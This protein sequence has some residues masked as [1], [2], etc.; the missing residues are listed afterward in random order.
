MPALHATICCCAKM[1]RCPWAFAFK[2]CRS[3]PGHPE[4]RNHSRACASPPISRSVSGRP[5]SRRRPQHDR[6]LEKSTSKREP[7]PFQPSRSGLP[8]LDR[9]PSC[10][11]SS[12]FFFLSFSS[13]L[14]P[15]RSAKRRA[16]GQAAVDQRSYL[17]GFI[18]ILSREP[19]VARP[20]AQSA[21]SNSRERRAES[22]G[23]ERRG[24]RERRQPRRAA[25]ALHLPHFQSFSISSFPA[26]HDC[27]PTPTLT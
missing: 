19:F 9:A 13:P 4:A 8:V 6:L 26:D 10:D 22:R 12:T 24:R 2:R 7:L 5:A 3:R 17:A 25:A 20:K 16:E 14:F 23:Q 21:E 27:L 18:L 1:Q 15:S 11:I